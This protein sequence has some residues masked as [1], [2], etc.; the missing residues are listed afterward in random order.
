LFEVNFDEYLDVTKFSRLLPILTDAAALHLASKTYKIREKDIDSARLGSMRDAL[1]YGQ[2]SKVQVGQQVAPKNEGNDNA[3][4][5][6][7]QKQ[8]DRQSREEERSL[9]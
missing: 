8:E 3:A 4:K 1:L 9:E 5:D 7:L 2:T 6:D